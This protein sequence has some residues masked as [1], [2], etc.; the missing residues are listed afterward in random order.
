MSNC[1]IK[2]LNP[3]LWWDCNASQ[4]A[5]V[6][7][8]APV[9]LVSVLQILLKKREPLNYPVPDGSAGFSSRLAASQDMMSFS[10]P[11]VRYRLITSEAAGSSSAPHTG[12]TFVWKVEFLLQRCIKWK[13]TQSKH[14]AILICTVI[15][16]H[17]CLFEKISKLQRK[18]K[19]TG[20][21]WKIKID[22]V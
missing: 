2:C 7:V 11:S 13:A 21:K 4:S 12:T 18:P 20:W 16:H 19:S 14:V 5:V 15:S 8:C 22:H 10:P 17:K 9:S 6:K 3:C 1:N